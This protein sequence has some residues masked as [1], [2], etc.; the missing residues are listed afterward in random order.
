[1]EGCTRILTICTLSIFYLE[2]V[3]LDVFVNTSPIGHPSAMA[4][5]A[6]AFFFKSIFKNNITLFVHLNSY[7]YCNLTYHD[8]VM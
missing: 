4:A 7:M 2:T 5:R 6:K 3:T 1:M 8:N